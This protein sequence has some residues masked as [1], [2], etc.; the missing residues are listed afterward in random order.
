MLRRGVIRAKRSPWAAFAVRRAL[1][2]GSET[3]SVMSEHLI[4][5]EEPRWLRLVVG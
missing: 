1:A 5:V 4:S 2:L 3:E